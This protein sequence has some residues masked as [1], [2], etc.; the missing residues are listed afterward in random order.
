MDGPL[1]GAARLGCWSGWSGW[2]VWLVWLV[3]EGLAA[4]DG[5]VW[6]GLVREGRTGRGRGA[7]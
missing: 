6:E 4:A 3:G 1:A 7:W 5:R 2:R